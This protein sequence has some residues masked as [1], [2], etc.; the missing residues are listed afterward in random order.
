[1]EPEKVNFLAS[2]NKCDKK[3][4]DFESYLTEINNHSGK[5]WLMSIDF[6][7]NILFIEVIDLLEKILI[8]NPNQRLNSVEALEHE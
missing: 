8:W 1:M 2:L 7:L 3:R 6:K 4:V 5:I